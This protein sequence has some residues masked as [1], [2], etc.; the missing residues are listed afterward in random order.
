MICSQIM[1]AMMENDPLKKA[2][3]TICPP[4]EQDVFFQEQQF[5]E[6]LGD[7]TNPIRWWQGNMPSKEKSRRKNTGYG[8]AIIKDRLRK[9][10]A[11][12]D[13]HENKD[14]ILKVLRG[15]NEK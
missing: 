8:R 13:G 2:V 9:A 1:G 6:A 15:Q 3:V 7:G 4:A 14:K 12:L 5:D 10:E 11:A